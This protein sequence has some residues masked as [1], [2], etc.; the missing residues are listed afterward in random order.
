MTKKEMEDLLVEKYGY[1][2][3]ELKDEKGNRLN[4]S[5]LEEMIAKEEA[6]GSAEKEDS[7]DEASE[8]NFSLDETIFEASHNLG[9]KDLVLC[10]SGVNGDLN[11]SSPLSNFRVQTKD[12]GQTMKIPYGDLAYVHNIAPDAFEQG[13]I[14][15]L[16]KQVQQEFGLEDVYKHVITPKNV[17]E[18]I[19]LEAD[20]L[21]DF[22]AQMPKAMKVSLYNEARK[23]YQ[24]GK[25]DSIKTV[26]VIEEE[27]N[28]SLEDNAPINNE[29]KQ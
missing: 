10:M 22:L 23:M 25:I 4:N 11:F 13:K 21:Q 18:V 29:V 15:I 3:K 7:K 5:V 8:D 27:Y 20:E 26:K 24:Q 6:E 12:F 28:V 1:D 14:V 17:R 19:K 9:D 2:R 16:N